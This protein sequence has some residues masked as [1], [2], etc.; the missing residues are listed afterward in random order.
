VRQYADIDDYARYTG[1]PL[2]GE[3]PPLIMT[4]S[5]MEVERALIGARYNVDDNFMPTDQWV[6]DA[7]R[8]ATCAQARPKVRKWAYPDDPD[9][10]PP[11]PFQHLTSEAWDV[12]QSAGL[13]PVMPRLWG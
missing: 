11:V 1:E 13:V 5:S 6:I 9:C 2:P 12:L 8:D 7:L 10:C 3:F 4:K